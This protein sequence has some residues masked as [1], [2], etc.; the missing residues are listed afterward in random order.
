[1]TAKERLAGPPDRLNRG[2][3]A[4]ESGGSKGPLSE[5][6]RE[7][8]LSGAE[9]RGLLRVRTNS[10]SVPGLLRHGVAELAIPA[11]SRGL[12]DAA[13]VGR[14]AM[15]KAVGSPVLGAC[16]PRRWASGT[17]APRAV[18]GALSRPFAGDHLRLG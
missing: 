12:D 4:G 2:T 15:G 14:G 5:S 13:S 3:R 1:M 18:A 16:L 8:H 11:L 9:R 10:G 17:K 7:G 6:Q